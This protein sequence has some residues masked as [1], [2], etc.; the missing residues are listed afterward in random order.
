MTITTPVIAHSTL[1]NRRVL[2]KVPKVT[3]LFWIIKIL[4]G[5]C[6]SSGKRP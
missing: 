5:S 1:M 4:T 6:E 2:N 3:V